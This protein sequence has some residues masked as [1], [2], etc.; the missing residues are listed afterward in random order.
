MYNIFN[1]GNNNRRR[2]FRGRNFNRRGFRNFR[3]G[4]FG[5]FRNMRRGRGFRRATRNFRAR[6]G[7][8]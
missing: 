6:R 5:N 3:R 2:V 7:R 1:M 4:N 8:V